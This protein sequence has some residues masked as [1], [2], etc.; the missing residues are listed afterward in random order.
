MK[1]EIARLASIAEAAK[2]EFIDLRPITCDPIRRGWYCPLFLEDGE[3]LYWDSNHWTEA[4]AR[5]VGESLRA[6]GELRLP[7]L[8]GCRPVH[9]SLLRPLLRSCSMA[10][11][12][13]PRRNRNHPP[14]TGLFAFGL[15]L[16]APLAAQQTVGG[17]QVL[18]V[19][20]IWNTPVASLPVAANSGAVINHIGAADTM[21]P[22][23]GTVWEGAPIGIPYVTVPNGQAMLPID[24]ASLDGWPGESDPGPYPIPP[25]PPIEGGDDPL[26]LG[27]RHIL[28]VRQG[29][30]TLY[31][32][33]HSWK[34]GDWN[35]EFTC[36]VPGCDTRLVRPVGG[37]LRPRF[38]RPAAGR[39]DLGRRRRPA[40][41]SRSGALRRGRNRRDP[42]RPALHGRHLAHELGLA[43]PPR[44]PARPPTST[45][46]R[47]GCGCA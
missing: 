7:V 13:D 12:T 45:P 23:F 15:L 37:G 6:S 32:L 27:D 38:E 3:L 34:E 25:S 35:G 8:S 41:L 30:C 46:R 22:D 9:S 19:A 40:D 29:A 47:W 1:Q 20:N 4:G 28:V 33:Y 31:E 42:P 5:R 14:F 16:T 24:F 36:A 26:N 43:G 11:I 44:R 18:P 21:H 39:L 2:V 10:R 17:C